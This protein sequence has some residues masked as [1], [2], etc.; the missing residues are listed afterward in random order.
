MQANR[1]H[2]EAAL[3]SN[4]LHQYADDDLEGVLPVISKIGSVRSEWKNV[5]KSIQYF[6]KTG[7]LPE[8]QPESSIFTRAENAPGLAELKVELNRLNVNISKYSKKLE[9]FPDHKKIEQWRED[10]AKMEA[11]K[12]ELKQDIANLTYA[13]K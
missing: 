6:D 9:T 8:E 10:L 5:K 13:S 11:L 2:L 4:T 12:F 1:L 3:L 7:K